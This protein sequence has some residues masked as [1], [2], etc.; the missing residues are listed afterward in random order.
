MKTDSSP[1]AKNYIS[2]MA[3]TVGIKIHNASDRPILYHLTIRQINLLPEI[4]AQRLQFATRRSEDRDDRL[5]A[6]RDRQSLRRLVGDDPVDKL[7]HREKQATKT[8]IEESKK[9]HLQMHLNYG[10]KKFLLDASFKKLHDEKKAIQTEYAILGYGGKENYDKAIAGLPWTDAGLPVNGDKRNMSVSN[11][12]REKLPFRLPVEI[13]ANRNITL[14]KMACSDFAR[15]HSSD[16]VWAMLETENNVKCYEPLPMNELRQ[17]FKSAEK[18]HTKNQ[19]RKTSG[20]K[21]LFTDTANAKRLI[22]E[23]REYI[24]YISKVKKW[25]FY[26]GTRWV[27]DPPGGL[28]PLVRLTTEG[29][30]QYAVNLEGDERGKVLKEIRGLENLPRQKCMIDEAAT[31]PEV[32]VDPAYLDKDHNLLNV[33][34]GSIDTKTG[35]L[36]PH[37]PR[38]LIT[39]LAPVTYD[40][41]ATCTVFEDF[42]HK[43]MGG[44][45]NLISFLGRAI[46]YTLTGETNEQ[47]FFFWYGNG[48]NGK[49]TLLN[50]IRNLLGDYAIQAQAEMLMVKNT[51]GGANNDL[52]RLPGARFVATSET[53]DGQRFAESALKQMTGQDTIT[54][55]FLYGEFFEF[56][57]QFKI[58]LAANHKPVI[59]GTDNAIWRRI[60]LIPFAVTIPEAEQDRQLEAKLVNELPGIL[61]WA[62]RGCAEWRKKGLQPPE[63]VKLAVKEYRLDMDLF[64]QWLEDCCVQSP[65]AKVSHKALYASYSE[66]SEA[67]TGWKLSSNKMGRII[68]ERGFIKE[69]TPHHF[70]HGIGLRS[71]DF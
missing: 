9:T 5:L 70:W 61:N 58:F 14:F 64:S 56:T 24:R 42:L 17:L 67:N 36:C 37:N 6:I 69:Q 53:E 23:H 26:D 54:A 63:E 39:K 28:F 8:F 35:I 22:E 44:N 49:S 1:K 65:N 40:Q 18:Q 2:P 51:H 62:L 48:A 45:K 27:F 59:R 4:R 50:T 55:R 12:R 21:L 41:S 31:M 33:N 66:W 29:L 10:E 60:Y 11:R 57:P 15:N 34:N 71:P 19:A 25:A 46:G 20:A 52:A 3:K 7:K 32:I 38:D 68:A 13:D 30:Y 16:A 43:I 47:C